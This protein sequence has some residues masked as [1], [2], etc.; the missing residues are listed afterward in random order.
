MLPAPRPADPVLA[1]FSPSLA[2]RAAV[3]S[4]RHHREALPAGQEP[5]TLQLLHI[6]ERFHV[7]VDFEK[8]VL[9]HILGGGLIG[10]TPLDELLEGSM[11]RLP[12]VLCRHRHTQHPF[13]AACIACPACCK[14]HPQESSAPPTHQRRG[15][16]TRS[17]LSGFRLPA[18]TSRASSACRTSS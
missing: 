11:K 9:Q 2:H 17:E 5:P 14:A 4:R 1:D 15:W 13:S 10:N 12:D 8:H 16:K 6:F 7:L 18:R 3:R